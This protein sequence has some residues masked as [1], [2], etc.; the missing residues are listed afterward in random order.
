[1]AWMARRRRGYG[2]AIGIAVSTSAWA[3]T[4]LAFV[5]VVWRLW[6]VVGDAR[7]NLQILA[8]VPIVAEMPSYVAPRI[9]RPEPP[10][11]GL[12]TKDAGALRPKK[13]KADRIADEMHAFGLLAILG[14][15]SDDAKLSSV[16]EKNG[17]SMADLVGGLDGGYEG[18]VVGG[19]V[20]GTVIGEGRGLG[21]LGL[22]GTGAGGGGIASLGSGGGRAGRLGTEQGA[23]AI[24]ISDGAAGSS[25]VR[26]AWTHR[27]G[28]AIGSRWMKRIRPLLPDVHDE[29]R[30]NLRIV[31]DT[32]G[33]V[34]KIDVVRST[35]T[36]SFDQSALDAVRES[37]LPPPPEDLLDEYG[38]ARTTVTVVLRFD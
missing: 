14:K 25:P 37:R 18:G 23:T 10:S 8:P 9:A 17:E 13:A 6:H 27:V 19:V 12:G 3:H 30:I 26:S 7:P 32:E 15:S 4:F 34:S 22:R 38:Y 5:V 28:T 31:V 1:M 2:F 20:G 16:L 29:L 11:G 36:D 21:G 35:G 33:G 24:G